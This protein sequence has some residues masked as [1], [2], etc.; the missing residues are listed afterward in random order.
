MSTDETGRKA[1]GE[2]VTV[3]EAAAILGVTH[4]AVYK[5]IQRGSIKSVTRY[6]KVRAIKRAELDRYRE[7]RVA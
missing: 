5:A 7:Q 1:A 2:T 4:Q 6:V 3:Q